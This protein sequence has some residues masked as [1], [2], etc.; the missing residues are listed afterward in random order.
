MIEA[1]DKK[2]SLMGAAIKAG[3]DSHFVLTNRDGDC[4][5]PGVLPLPFL[6]H[7]AATS[8]LLP[9]AFPPA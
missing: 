8:D 6:P 5:G 9:L 4:I 7:Q 1:H 3:Y 2:E